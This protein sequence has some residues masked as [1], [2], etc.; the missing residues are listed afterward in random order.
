MVD[1]TFTELLIMHS[2]Y[3]M[4]VLNGRFKLQFTREKEFILIPD[5]EIVNTMIIDY[6]LRFHIKI[7][8][9]THEN[10]KKKTL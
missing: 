7:K 10:K 3:F 5:D 9:P 8:Q 4:R 1:E 6:T 2:E